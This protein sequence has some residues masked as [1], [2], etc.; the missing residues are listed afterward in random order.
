MKTR[1]NV[2][3]VRVLEEYNDKGE[4]E[5]KVK[6]ERVSNSQLTPTKKNVRE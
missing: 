3:G 1:G 2:Q 5:V 6:R 4:M